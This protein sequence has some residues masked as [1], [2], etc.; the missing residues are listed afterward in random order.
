MELA[1]PRFDAPLKDARWE[2]FLPPDYKYEDFLGTMSYE[3]ADL[4][5]VVQD[6]TIAEYARQEGA[7]ES[8]LEAEAVDFVRKARSD[9]A[10]GKLKDT[11]NRLSFFRSRSVRDETTARELKQLEEDVNR[12]QSSNLINA[13]Q[14]LSV[15]NAEVGCGTEQPPCRATGRKLRLFLMLERPRSRSRNCRKPRLLPWHA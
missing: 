8:N 1:S 5:P 11:G 7:K 6:F 4:S 15:E 12:A 13:Q 10:A 14:A 2:L 9:I 3:R